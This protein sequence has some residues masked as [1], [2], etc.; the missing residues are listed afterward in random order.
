VEQDD[1]RTRPTDCPVVVADI[2][3]L[4]AATGWQPTIPF[5]ESLRRVLAYWRQVT[6]HPGYV[7]ANEQ[8]TL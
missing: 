2:T 4:E 8:N 7:P 1:A 3:R 5:E 6:L